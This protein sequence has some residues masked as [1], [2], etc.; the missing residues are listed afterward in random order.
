M[1]FTLNVLI[2]A[3]LYV[4]AVWAQAS[5]IGFPAPGTTLHFGT[6]FTLQLVRPNSIQG[7]TEV[8]IAIG[9]LGCPISQG[10][11]CPSPAGQLGQI[12][13]TGPFNPTIHPMAMFYESFT[14]T[15][16]TADFSPAGPAPILE[17]NN[18]TVNL[19]N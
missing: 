15:V 18:I 8:G 1:Q 7:S 4:A 9:L 10:P 6:N 11:A 2:F 13:Y 19:A 3:S 16:P 17:L 12:L 14:L 5:H